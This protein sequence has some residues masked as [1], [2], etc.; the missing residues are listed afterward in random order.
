MSMEE[1]IEEQD[2]TIGTCSNCCK[3]E[4]AC[5]CPPEMTEDEKKEALQDALR[6]A[7]D[8]IRPGM[9][10]WI[11]A[12]PTIEPNRPEWRKALG[13]WLY[14]PEDEALL[15]ELLDRWEIEVRPPTKQGLKRLIMEFR[16]KNEKL[17]SPEAARQL[18]RR[19]EQ[20][21]KQ[22]ELEKNPTRQRMQTSTALTLL[23]GLL[24]Q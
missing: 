1:N 12:S 18:A 10:C 6:L 8:G 21:R 9:S 7:R 15:R 14:H 17:N 24:G 13:C 19:Q 3:D 23:G 4:G 11:F 22:L 16:K 5:D 20:A 2:P